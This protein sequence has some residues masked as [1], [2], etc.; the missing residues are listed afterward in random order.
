MIEKWFETFTL[1][2]KSTSADG[3]GGVQ[4]EYAP[5]LTF[6]GALTLTPGKEQSAAGQ[7]VL[8]EKPVLLHEFDLT[9]APGDYVRREKDGA[10][11]RVTDRSDNMRAPAYSG[12]RFCQVNVERTVIPC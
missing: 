12:L 11:Y 2:E 9:L 4:Y 10:V 1:L 3:A 8:L 6:Q 7:F 5:S